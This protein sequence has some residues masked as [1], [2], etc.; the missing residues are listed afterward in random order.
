MAEKGGLKSERIKEAYNRANNWTVF[1]IHT[2]MQNLSSS[3][4]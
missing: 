4:N 2:S 1:M 3:Y